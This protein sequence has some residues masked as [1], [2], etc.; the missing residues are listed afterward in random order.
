MTG[1]NNDEDNS[2]NNSHNNS[3]KRRFTSWRINTTLPTIKR[4][5]VPRNPQQQSPRVRSLLEPFHNSGDVR[6]VRTGSTCSSS[7]L[8]QAGGGFGGGTT[9]RLEG[10]R[11]RTGQRS[12]R[13]GVSRTTLHR[14]DGIPP[15]DLQALC[16]LK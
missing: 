13:A 15:T 12:P 2:N 5:G 14:G 8:H 3:A 11:Q 10:G 16:H 7:L 1:N 9:P 4:L 6:L